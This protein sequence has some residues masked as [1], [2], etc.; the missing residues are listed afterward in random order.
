MGRV[1]RRVPP[2]WEHPKEDRYGRID[3]RPM[4]DESYEDAIAE[5]IEN[6]RLWE[7]G[8][9]PHQEDAETRAKYRYYAEW[10]GNPPSVDSYRPKWVDGEATWY[11]V[12]ETVSEG[13]PVTPPFATQDELIAYLATYGDEWD[14]RRTDRAWSVES[15]T[16]FVKGTG[17]R[18]SAIS[19]NGQFVDQ[20]QQ[21]I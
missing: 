19:I 2:N 20:N 10:A 8:K 7:E 14:Q 15:A 9:H 16:N 6:H 4:F 11:Q 13:T 3:Y 21:V 17:W 5:W 18:P 12:Y 1:I